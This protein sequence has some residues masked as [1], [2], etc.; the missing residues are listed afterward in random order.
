[1]K[2]HFALMLIGILVTGCK[3][4][5]PTTDPFF[6]RTT[7]P[8]PPTGSVMGCPA[9]D[10]GYQLPPAGPTTMTSPSAAGS[11]TPSVQLPS[12]PTGASSTSPTPT[13]TPSLAPAA[14]APPAATTPPAAVPSTAPAGNNSLPGISPSVLAP[15]PSSSMPTKA[16]TPPS[17]SPTPPSGSA[18]PYPSGGAYN[19]RGTPT[20][21]TQNSRTVAPTFT[22]VAATRVGVS[23]DDRM[24]RPVDDAAASVGIAGQK[25]IVRTIQPRGRDDV[26]DNVVDIT[27]LPKSQ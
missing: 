4:Q 27:D 18:S 19:Y 5:A 20:A 9:T 14:A 2:W 16:A 6:G 12:Q 11:L 7:I 3:S 8:P 24:P 15:R 23:G 22:N 21:T 1:M 26:S 17:T 25:P 13:P 10:P